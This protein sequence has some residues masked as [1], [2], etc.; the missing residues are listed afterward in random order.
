MVDK[1]GSIYASEDGVLK[2]K[3]Y[4]IAA[5][6]GEEDYD[7]LVDSY[8]S[9]YDV[10]EES[11]YKYKAFSFVDGGEEEEYKIYFIYNDGL[12]TEV[13]FIDASDE[14]KNTILNSLELPSALELSTDSTGE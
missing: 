11:D 8:S 3:A 9:Y 13:M 7:T 4:I 10:T 2:E 6:F 12:I 1:N 14:E 5:E